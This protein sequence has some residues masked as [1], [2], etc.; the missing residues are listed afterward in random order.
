MSVETQDR[1]EKLKGDLIDD[2]RIERKR[3]T[4]AERLDEIKQRIYL[5]GHAYADTATSRG[6]YYDAGAKA[7]AGAKF[8]DVLFELD[9]IIE[10]V[11]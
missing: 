8:D 11:R 1:I 2:E 5:A 3:Q 4:T 6:D 10:E 7:R 9:E